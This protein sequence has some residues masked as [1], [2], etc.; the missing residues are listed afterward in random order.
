MGLAIVRQDELKALQELPMCARAVVALERKNTGVDHHRASAHRCGGLQHRPL[1][2]PAALEVRPVHREHRT[3]H[4]RKQGLSDRT[5]NP[6]ALAVQARIS[7][8]SV[9]GLDVMLDVRTSGTASPE[10]RQRS[11]ASENERLHYPDEC[12]D[13]HRVSDN[14]P[15]LQPS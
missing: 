8:Q 13:S 10:L 9:H 14:Q 4:A 11:P 2:T 3:L 6:G 12:R 1:A 15:L 7:Q 5:V